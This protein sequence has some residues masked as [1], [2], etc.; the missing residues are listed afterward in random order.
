LVGS[1]DARQK[2]NMKTNWKW[3]F[4]AYFFFE[5]YTDFFFIIKP[6]ANESFLKVR[7]IWANDF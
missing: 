1:K 5:T 7:A 2:K 3:I 6:L 4:N